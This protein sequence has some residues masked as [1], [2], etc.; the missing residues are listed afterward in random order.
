M[1]VRRLRLQGAQGAGRLDRDAARSSRR[2]CG[3]ARSR[4]RAPVPGKCNGLF[5]VRRGKLRKID[6][7]VPAET[8]LR[9]GRVAYLF[10][11]PGDTLPQ[12]DPGAHAAPQALAGRR[13]RVRRGE[14]ELRGQQPGADEPLHPLAAGGPGAQ[15]V[16]RGPRAGRARATRRSSSRSARS[17][18]A[19][20]RSRSRASA[21]TTRT[22]GAST[23]RPTRRRSSRPAVRLE[24]VPD[25]EVITWQTHRSAS[26][27]RPSSTRSGREKIREYAN[28]VGESNPVHHDPEAAQG[29]GI[30]RRRRATHVLRRLLGRRDGAG[31]PRPGA[32]HQPDADGARRA[33]VRVAASRCAPATRSRRR[34]QLKDV[35]DKKGMTFYVFESESTNQDGQTT[36]KGTWTNIVRGG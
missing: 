2:R 26:S 4:S 1:A 31:D 10:I 34:R 20:T 8:D 6:N 12:P 17:P 15:R 9:G 13:D 14:G 19:S 25:R 23:S 3:S 29:G 18:A 35:F 30:P 27:T 24:P 11:P 16:L 7:R 5:V 36:V 21:S 22:A 28:A 33:G 32:G